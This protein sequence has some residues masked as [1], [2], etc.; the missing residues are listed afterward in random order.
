MSMAELARRLDEVAQRFE[1]LANRLDTTYLRREIFNSYRELADASVK[2][3]S[4]RMDEM[5][6]RITEL[7][8][9]RKWLSRLVIGFIVVAVLGAVF[10]VAKTGAHP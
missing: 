1:A 5:K 7:E 6:A 10:T 3:Q 9:G 4:E 2:S 8:E